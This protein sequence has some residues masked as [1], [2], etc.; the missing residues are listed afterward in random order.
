MKTKKQK[1]MLKAGYASI[2][3]TVILLVLK[4]IAFVMTNSV[5]VL[6]TLFDSVQDLMTSGVNLLAIRQ[7]V[8]PADKQHRF[9]H[10]KAQAIGGLFQAFII[11]MSALILI[12]Q[13][14]LHWE[15]HDVPDVFSYG[16]LLLVIS[17]VL[18]FI[19]INFQKYVIAKTDSISIRADMA[20]YSGDIWMNLGV[21]ISLFF[22]TVFNIEWIDIL[23]GIGVGL[24]LIKTTYQIAS[25]AI[26]ILMDKEMPIH[27]RYKIK[28]IALSFSNV[29][30]IRDLKTRQSG[31]CLFIQMTVLM[32]KDLT[33]LQAH[34][35][36]D[37]IET[38]L[39]ERFSDS[40]IILHL[41]PDQK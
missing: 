4:W 2:S 14:C 22:S 23:F 27:I 37:E 16:T 13:S 24:Y 7:S 21:I 1:L 31:S 5:A 40:E 11:F 15:Q 8:V 12:Y 38:A 39:H 6:S 34:Q 18:T 28:A 9:G 35:T 26:G 3:L 41:E 30:Q 19:L 32:K 20:H 10:G 33:L 25:T 17:I 29:T 36:A